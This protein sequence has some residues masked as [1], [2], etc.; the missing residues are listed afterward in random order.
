[1]EWGSSGCSCLSIKG[2]AQSGKKARSGAEKLLHFFQIRL[3]QADLSGFRCRQ[4]VEIRGAPEANAHLM[5]DMV[6]HAHQEEG[7]FFPVA[8]YPM[9]IA[10]DNRQRFGHL[11]VTEQPISLFSMQAV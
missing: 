7:V 5:T 9:M 1:M 8:F 10:G 3:H 2:L 6:G 11:D 4:Q